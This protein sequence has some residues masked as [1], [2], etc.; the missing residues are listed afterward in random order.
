MTCALLTENY[1]IY[2]EFSNV[3]QIRNIAIDAI[4]NYL[5]FE[6]FKI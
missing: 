6:L 5:N 3:Y 4:K 1:K 2:N